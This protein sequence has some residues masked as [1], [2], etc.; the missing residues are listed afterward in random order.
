MR[1][2]DQFPGT[3][4]TAPFRA[5]AAIIPSDTEDLP[6]HQIPRALYCTGDGNVRVS[7]IDSD[8]P[9]TLPMVAGLP[10]PGRVTRVWATGTDATDIVGVW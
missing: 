9:V 7:L 10:L 6:P 1:Q 4:H 3:S 8:D 2:D 5:G